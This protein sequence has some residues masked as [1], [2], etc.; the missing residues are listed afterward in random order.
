MYFYYKMI[1]ADFNGN[2][3]IFTEKKSKYAPPFPRRGISRFFTRQKPRKRRRPKKIPKIF[4][5]LRID[6]T[7]VRG[8]NVCNLYYHN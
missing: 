8:Y 3:S 2:N 6:N 5:I 4:F 7:A 1:I